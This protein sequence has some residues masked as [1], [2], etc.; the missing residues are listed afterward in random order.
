MGLLR[1]IKLGK[2][3]LLL[4]IFPVA[5]LLYFSITS[6]IEKYSVMV[7]MSSLQTLATL[8]APIGDLVHATQRELGATVAY[9]GSSGERF[10]AELN[11]QRLETDRKIGALNAFLKDFNVAEY[12]ADFGQCLE[13]ALAELAQIETTREAVSALNIAADEAIA[14][15]TYMDSSFLDTVALIALLSTNVEVAIRLG[16]VF[17]GYELIFDRAW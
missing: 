10:E 16:A 5:G 2:K 3:L 17:D 6:V 7:E 11:A 12:G 1:N 8:A 14:Y 13:G 15:Y 4:M 9:L